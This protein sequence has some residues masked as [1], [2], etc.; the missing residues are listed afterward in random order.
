MTDTAPEKCP[1]CGSRKI[2]QVT[3]GRD[4]AS[5]WFCLDCKTNTSSVVELCEGVMEMAMEGRK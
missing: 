4:K 5:T 1:K 3:R 2:I